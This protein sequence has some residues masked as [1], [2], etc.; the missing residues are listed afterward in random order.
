MH[1]KYSHWRSLRGDCVLKLPWGN[2]ESADQNK[3]LGP[4]HRNR[5]FAVTAFHRLH[6]TG[7]A[8]PGARQ[9][10]AAPSSPEQRPPMQQQGINKSFTRLV[11]CSTVSQANSLNLTVNLTSVTYTVPDTWPPSSLLRALERTIPSLGAGLRKAGGCTFCPAL[12]EPPVMWVSPGGETQ[13]SDVQ[14]WQGS[15]SGSLKTDCPLSL[16]VSQVQWWKIS[17]TWFKWKY[18]IN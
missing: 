7:T 9:S 10:H 1:L 16:C 17:T 4:W 2:E 5:R 8:G 3:H 6:F 14:S 11:P 12:L 18:G 13:T 15:K